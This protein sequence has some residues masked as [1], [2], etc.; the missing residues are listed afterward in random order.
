[1]K[2]FLS[3]AV[4]FGLVAGVAATASALE[5]KVKGKYQL[6][7]YWI[8]A[9]S[10]MLSTTVSADGNS[11]AVHPWENGYDSDWYQ[12]TFKI[13]ADLI[14][15]DK[16]KVRSDIRLIDSNTVWPDTGGTDNGGYVD[17]NKL[18]LVYDSPIGKFEIG[19]RPGGAW[20]TDFVSS[21][22]NADRIFW[23]FPTSGAFKGYAFLQKQEENDMAAGIDSDGPLVSGFNGGDKDY[24]EVGLG[25]KT[26][27]VTVYGALATSQKDAT[28]YDFWRTKVW[29]K[30]AAG[31]GAVVF[32]GDYKFGESSPTVDI[33]SYA[34]MA[35]Y[36][37]KAGNISYMAGY[38]TISGDNDSDATENNAYDP[39]HGTGD[40][41]E[42]LYILTGNRTN[43]LNGDAG[44]TNI[45]RQSG[46][47]ALVGTVDYAVNEDLTLH[48]GIG[49]G[50]ADDEPA[51]WD[52]AYGW[53]LDAGLAYKLYQNLTYE[54]HFGY[55]FVG[56]FAE[57]GGTLKTD[58]VM[59][60]SNHLSMSF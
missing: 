40:D 44:G 35:G 9:A 26:D 27:A 32:E 57:A 1:M 23:H 60:L 50:M 43:V 37:G 45:V 49:W 21:S 10:T 18:W 3:A 56:D 52:D 6:D 17:V 16:I 20:G 15:N 46:V 58:D 13:N 41:F 31:P 2:K 51:G 59:L 4:A 28:G 30:V 11:Y 38:A 19:R 33:S 54:L 39:S 29:G 42:P 36:M 55:W 34:F 48:G 25:Y 53:E 47:H 8:D 7:G 24:Y 12:H 22:T 5:L 14:V